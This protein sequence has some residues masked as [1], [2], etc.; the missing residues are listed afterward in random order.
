M[1]RLAPAKQPSIDEPA[2]VTHGGVDPTLA[3]S[4]GALVPVSRRECEAE[5]TGAGGNRTDHRI[6]DVVIR[7]LR[8]E[9]RVNAEKAE[10]AEK[11]WP[12]GR[13]RRPV[14]PPGHRGTRVRLA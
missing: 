14:A 11:R 6:T 12:V 8:L 3:S 13:A 4:G 9:V 10:R 2:G 7:Q 1:S 5:R